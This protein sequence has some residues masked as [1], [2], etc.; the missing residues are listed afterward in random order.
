MFKFSEVT[1]RNSQ[2]FYGVFQCGVYCNNLRNARYHVIIVS[3][4]HFSLSVHHLYN[5]GHDHDPYC[6]IDQ[7]VISIYP[8]PVLRCAVDVP[9]NTPHS[10][11]AKVLPSPSQE[12]PSLTPA[13]SQNS[14]TTPTNPFLKTSLKHLHLTPSDPEPSVPAPVTPTA[15]RKQ[16]RNTG[17]VTAFVDQQER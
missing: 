2:Y 3:H 8:L 1:E 4:T 11:S 15:F 7:A 5:H 14:A 12:S 17:L 6:P 13:A 16:R 9:T 10:A